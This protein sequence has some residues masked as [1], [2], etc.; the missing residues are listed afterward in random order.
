MNSPPP[1]Q[2]PTRRR[3]ES[4]DIPTPH[5]A[6]SSGP[7]HF[8]WVAPVP[9][10]TAPERSWTSPADRRRRGGRPLRRPRTNV[11]TTDTQVIQTHADDDGYPTERRR[12][13]PPRRFECSDDAVGGGEPER[14]PT[15]EHDRIDGLHG[16]GGSRSPNSRV[17]GAPPA[18]L[19]RRHRPLRKYDHRAARA[20]LGI[21]PVADADRRSPS[22]DPRVACA[23]TT[24]DGR[25]RCARRLEPPRL[26]RTGPSGLV[27]TSV[28]GASRTPRSGFSSRSG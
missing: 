13:A 25:G 2:P 12:V 11:R 20:G 5:P 6:W 22:A 1:E 28:P 8:P 7:P 19:A 27:S 14:R 21:G 9:A 3:P 18:D 4:D 24:T 17:A 16:G 15:A 10:P 26:G 23:D